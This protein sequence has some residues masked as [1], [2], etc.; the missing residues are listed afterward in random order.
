MPASATSVTS[1]IPSF[2]S[3]EELQEAV[4]DPS[5]VISAAKKLSVA[6]RVYRVDSRGKAH[7]KQSLWQAALRRCFGRCFGHRAVRDRERDVTVAL[8]QLRNRAIIRISMHGPEP[9][10]SIPSILK[11][12]SCSNDAPQRPQTQKQVHFS[13]QVMERYIDDISDGERAQKAAMRAE[14]FARGAK[15]ALRCAA[16]EA[17]F[18][19]ELA[20]A[21]GTLA[22]LEATRTR[23]SAR[24]QEL[25]VTAA[26]MAAGVAVAKAAVGRADVA[27]GECRIF[28]E[29]A[30]RAYEKA[31]KSSNPDVVRKE[32][33]KAEAQANQAA[34]AEERVLV[35]QAEIKEASTQ[36]GNLAVAAGVARPVH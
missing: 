34:L 11:A 8:Q 14:A 7:E 21:V 28:A 33:N 1:L 36:V 13:D 9:E 4:G 30:D 32:A 10:R 20:D 29:K 24:A 35:A 18:A 31:L 12:P 23:G 6:G 5:G 25:A 27:S 2:T 17:M 16:E 15:Q 22:A 3:L 26:A 19:E